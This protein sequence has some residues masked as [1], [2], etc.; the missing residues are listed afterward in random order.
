MATKQAKITC[1]FIL[2]VALA[3]SFTL[4]PFHINRQN[5]RTMYDDYQKISKRITVKIIDCEKFESDDEISRRIRVRFLHPF[6]HQQMEMDTVSKCNAVSDYCNRASDGY[7]WKGNNIMVTY[8]DTKPTPKIHLQHH[9]NI[10][11]FDKL[12]SELYFRNCFALTIMFWWCL[13]SFYMLY[14]DNIANYRWIIMSVTVVIMFVT[15]SYCVFNDIRYQKQIHQWN[16]VETHMEIDT[17]DQFDDIN[18]NVNQT[19]FDVTFKGSKY[20]TY[21]HNRPSPNVT[22]YCPNQKFKVYDTCIEYYSKYYKKGSHIP[23]YLSKIDPD[24]NVI[25]FPIFE[26]RNTYQISV[27]IFTV[28]AFITIIISILTIGLVLKEKTKKD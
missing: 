13:F 15:V 14:I 19:R 9:E 12:N 26:H 5:I 17:V 24:D 3:S 27:I 7:F 11:H 28:M 1:G 6:T 18:P 16:Y 22:I 23:I 8:I 2:L 20:Y 4:L 25:G 21:M 10:H